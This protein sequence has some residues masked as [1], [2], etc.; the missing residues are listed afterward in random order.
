MK[1]LRL[2]EDYNGIKQICINYDI[3][4]YTINQDGSVDVNCGVELSNKVLHK[5]MSKLP[6]IFNKV[7]GFFACSDVGLKTLKGCP[8]IVKGTFDVDY[9]KLTTLL[10]GPVEV[11][12]FYSC[13]R[14]LLK[15]VYGYSI[16]NN[17]ILEWDLLEWDSYL[18]TE[19]FF[20]GNPVSE[21]I[22]VIGPKYKDR[23]KFIFWLNEYDV[24][25]DGNKIVEMRLEEAYYMTM[26]KELPM[27]K[28]EFEYYTLI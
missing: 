6:L 13:K 25:R 5:K 24:I 9:N 17:L 11:K 26:K 27:G 14:N 16:Y 1:Y 20:S 8:K 19:D 23:V 15:D 4:R 2:Y 21:I 7:N 22:S 18:N 10:E 12:L 3:H 28:R